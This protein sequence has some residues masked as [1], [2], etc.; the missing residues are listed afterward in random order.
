[1]AVNRKT[2]FYPADILLP[3]TE[4]ER[5]SVVACDQF[6]SDPDYWREVEERTE[7]VPS[8]AHSIFPEAKLGKVDFE[9]AS[10][11]AARGGSRSS[12]VPSVARMREPE[13]V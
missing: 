10:R 5:W 8:S 11:M 6:T 2:G 3:K 12:T 9:A 4:L 7:G 1:M 13:P